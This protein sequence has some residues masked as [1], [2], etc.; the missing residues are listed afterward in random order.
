MHKIRRRME[1]CYYNI[2]KLFGETIQY[3][4]KVDYNKFN[5]YNV[6]SRLRTGEL[7]PEAGG[8]SGSALVSRNAVLIFLG[9]TIMHLCLSVCLSSIYVKVG[10]M[11]RMK[12]KEW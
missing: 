7:Q 3:K 1:L 11:R 12:G 4:L 6:K 2:S 5:M 8:K 10:N 9:S